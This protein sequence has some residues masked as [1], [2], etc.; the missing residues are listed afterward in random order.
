MPK[1]KQERDADRK[2]FGERFTACMMHAGYLSARG[3]KAQFAA[4][5]AVKPPN[6]IGYLNGR[7]KPQADK[8]NAMAREFKVDPQ[9]FL[10]GVGAA[11]SWYQGSSTK[12]EFDRPARAPKIPGEEG[13]VGALMI[14][15]ESLAVG[16]LRALPAAAQPFL[17][18]LKDSASERGYSRR[19]GVLKMLSRIALAA[20]AREEEDALPVQLRGSGQS[21]KP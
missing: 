18:D 2:A 16:I 9:W 8:A 19:V 15:I 1:S 7:Q 13:D 21:R 11:P 6:V 5:Y 12:Q 3:G 14:G 4:K 20:G 10:L 17:D